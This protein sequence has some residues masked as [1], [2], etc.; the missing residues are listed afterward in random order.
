MTP[1]SNQPATIGDIRAL[2]ARIER[3][4]IIIVGRDDIKHSGLMARFE[5]IENGVEA[6]KKAIADQEEAR[7]R[8]QERIKWLLYGLTANIGLGV[9]SL[10]AR[11]AGWL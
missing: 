4:E 8:G 1:D 7:Q 3:L 6:I 2:T 5:L 10:I 11:A 9:I